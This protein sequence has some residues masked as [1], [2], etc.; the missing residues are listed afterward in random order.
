M[1]CIDWDRMHG[2][3]QG[4]DYANVAPLAKALVAANSKRILW[5]TDWPHP[6]SSQ[7]VGRQ[8]TD[9]APLYQI[10][11]GRLFNQLAVWIPDPH[12][13]KTILIDNPQR[14]YGF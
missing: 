11:D 2:R 5:G 13:R 6:D 1:P 9:I 10:D 7:V 4:P 3:S 12:L 8:P 14:L